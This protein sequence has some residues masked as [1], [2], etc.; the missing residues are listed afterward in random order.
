LSGTGKTTLSADSNR[1]LI[2]DDE[3]GWSK[4]GVF[5]FEGGCYAKVID[6][7]EEK[8]PEIYRAIRFGAI[9]ENTKFFPDTRTID[10]ED[11]SKTENTRVAYPIHF[12][13]NAREPSMG[14]VPKN[15]FFLTADAFGVLP[16]ISK[17]TK[18]QAMYH[19]L[20]G[21][22]AKVAGTEV[23]VTEP[24]ATFSPCFGE[25]F[26]P[27]HPTKYAEMLGEKMTE[28]ETA[29]WLINTGWTG[30]PH[31]EGERI[32]LEY[33]RAMITA[34]LNGELAKVDYQNHAIFGI[35]MPKSCPNVPSEALNPRETW[36]DKA[37]YD[38]KA[39]YLAK[40]FE[41]NFEQYAEFANEE[42]R[43][44]GPKQKS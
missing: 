8:E 27:L 38:E 22:T 39:K 3:H 23:G 18:G 42:I 37:A 6:L 24:K 9:V 13:D 41:E 29:V 12:I 26:L 35:A 2:G 28:S 7:T 21:Y 19:F 10:Y 36:K 16:P 11:G 40:L 33:T 17:L 30:G 34:A 43:G 15:I 25:A 31:G 32:Q 14:G 1:H 5:N 20:S 44:G 4:E